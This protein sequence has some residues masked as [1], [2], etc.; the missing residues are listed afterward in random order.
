MFVPVLASHITSANPRPTSD[1]NSDTNAVSIIF[2]MY[3]GE[4]TTKTV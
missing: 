2:Y 4:Y 3:V 1:E